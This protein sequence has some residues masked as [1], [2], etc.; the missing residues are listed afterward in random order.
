[1]VSRIVGLD[2]GQAR[3]YTAIAVLTRRVVSGGR[4]VYAVPYLERPPLG[5]TY[6]EIVARV[7]A[8]ARRPELRGAVWVA[9]ATGVGRAVAD[10]LAEA[11]RGVPGIR[12]LPVTIAAGGRATKDPVNGWLRVPKRE[13]VG[14]LK[15]VLA[16]RRLSV[17]RSLHEA[18]TLVSELEA[19]RVKVTASANETFGAWRERD[20]D[21][22]V[23]ATAL[24][25]W[26]GEVE[27]L[28]VG[29]VEVT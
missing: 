19:F 6:P 3:D 11:M 22:L 4:P 24:A 10:H 8:L 17:A 28:Y 25:A 20:H 2:L 12:L 5:L 1:M 26:A 13:I 23:L 29:P 14:A 15:A 9:D 27:M 16:S 21:D 18:E 7:V